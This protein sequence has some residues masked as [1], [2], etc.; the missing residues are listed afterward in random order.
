MC[1]AGGRGS[2]AR[3]LPALG[4]HHHSELPYKSHLGFFLGVARLQGYFQ[5]ETARRPSVLGGACLRGPRSSCLWAPP[6]RF[7]Q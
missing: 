1:G 4:P 6:F 2:W 5:E 3:L 7:N